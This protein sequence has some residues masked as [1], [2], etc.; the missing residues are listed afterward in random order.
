MSERDILHYTR[1]GEGAPLLVL[2]G[3]YG[4]NTNWGSHAKWMAEQ[5][6]VILPD[7]RNHGRSFHDADM[8][9]T[10]TAEDVRRL[11]DA[12]GL[13]SALLLGHS[14][15]GKT[16]MTLAL[17]EPERV[18][19]LVVADIAPVVYRH[20]THQPL[21]GAM[22]RLDLAQVKSRSDAEAALAA[23]IP[24]RTLRLFLLTNLERRG[25]RYAWRIPLD[26]LADQLPQL[27]DFPPV[28]GRYEGPALFLHGAES[29]Y[30]TEEA[31][32][33]IDGYFPNARVQALPNAGHWLHA[34]QPDAFADALRVFL[35][36]FRDQASD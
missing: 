9:Y 15:G 17:T 29:D 7:L 14:M 6:D 36:P 4:S 33:A 28:G 18:R 23:D 3:L 2:H 26:I 34:E 20:Q 1:Q 30:V 27:E 16:A 8:R 35:S 24:N 5:F 11:M 32:A 25:D 21:I 10:T 22:R 31:R 12:L 13:E 19:A